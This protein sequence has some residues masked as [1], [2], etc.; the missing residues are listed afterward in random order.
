MALARADLDAVE[1]IAKAVVGV[2]DVLEEQGVA[3]VEDVGGLGR[4]PEGTAESGCS[5][6]TGLLR[7][8]LGLPRS[9]AS[10]RLRSFCG[11]GRGSPRGRRRNG[12]RSPPA[13]LRRTGPMMSSESTSTS[14]PSMLATY[15][16]VGTAPGSRARR[17]A[18]VAASRTTACARGTGP[19]MARCRAARW[20]SASGGRRS[21][22][23]LGVGTGQQQAL[24]LA[25]RD[26]AIVDEAVVLGAGE[27]RA[28]RV[29][30]GFSSACHQPT[31][32]RVVSCSGRRVR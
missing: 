25:F 7:L 11:P 30:R 12:E 15:R 28:R 13:P 32:P 3:V 23:V 21:G 16:P 17:G 8:A 10:V 6:W 26:G 20:R 24:S 18:P 5:R 9:W 2:A 14:W 27:R 4:G 1:D 22:D 19:V 31:S 29:G